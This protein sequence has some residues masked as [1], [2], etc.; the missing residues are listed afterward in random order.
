MGK[1]CSIDS[2]AYV[3]VVHPPSYSLLRTTRLL[4]ELALLNYTTP[5]LLR[6]SFL[7]LPPTS[8]YHLSCRPQYSNDPPIAKLLNTPI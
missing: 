3:S 4:T 8:Q 6:G 5:D 2:I 7:S 1:G